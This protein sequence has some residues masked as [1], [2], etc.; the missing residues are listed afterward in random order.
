M[1]WHLMAF[2]F[3]SSSSSS[4][5]GYGVIPCFYRS[6]TEIWSFCKK[7][8]NI[9]FEKILIASFCSFLFPTSFHFNMVCILPVFCHGVGVLSMRNLWT[10]MRKNTYLCSPTSNW[11]LAFFSLC[12]KQTTV[13]SVASVTVTNRHT[14]SCYVPIVTEIL[15]YGL[16]SFPKLLVSPRDLI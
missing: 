7:S 16:N 5:F 4:S 1:L 8:N 11:N 13:L 6:N 9:E 2:S 10:W 3:L 14:I 12:R 15:K